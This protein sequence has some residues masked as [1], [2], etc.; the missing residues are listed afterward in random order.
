MAPPG[1]T[2]DPN[3][4]PADNERFQ[5]FTSTTVHHLREPVRM[6]AAYTEVLQ[7]AAAG[8]SGDA[9]QSLEF[10]G[11]AALQ[12]QRLLDG[13]SEFAAATAKLPRPP[14]L[15]RLELPLRQALLGLDADLKTAHAK[16]SYGDLPRVAGDYDRLQVVFHHLIQNAL[17][18]RDPG[19]NLEISVQARLEGEEWVIEVRDNGPGIPPEFAERVFELY[20]RLHGRTHPGNGLGLPICRAIIESLGGRMWVEAKAG[21]GATFCFTLDDHGSSG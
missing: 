17:Q 18:Y 3:Q 15:V 10:L 14:T 19:R 21:E 1:S 11:K 6:I 5:R 7:S 4:P 13:L 2:Q 12:M 9:L 8:L 16:V 20:S